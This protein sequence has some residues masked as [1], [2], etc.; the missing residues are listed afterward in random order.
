MLRDTSS[1]DAGGFAYMP[2][3]EAKAGLVGAIN[4]YASNFNSL[5]ANPG[6]PRED[7]IKQ[8]VDMVVGDQLASTYSITPREFDDGTQ[9]WCLEPAE[10]ID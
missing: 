2:L 10:S 8:S 3:D 1:I 4:Q 9:A 6:N 5:V 7:I